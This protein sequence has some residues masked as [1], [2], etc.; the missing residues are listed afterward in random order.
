MPSKRWSRW[1]LLWLVAFGVPV[2]YLL[3]SYLSFI[4]ARGPSPEPFPIPTTASAPTGNEIVL[5]WMHVDGSCLYLFPKDGHSTGPSILPIWPDG[6][7]AKQGPRSFLL[8][9]APEQEI[10]AVAISELMELHGQYVKTPPADTVVLPECA[11]YPL[12]LIGQMINRS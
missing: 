1:L 2:G 4:A 11:R 9:S 8:Y 7:N 10:A 3:V 5:A 6:F 12:F